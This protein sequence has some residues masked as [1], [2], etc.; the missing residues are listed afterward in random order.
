MQNNAAKYN[1]NALE[2]M[3]I[4]TSEQA[5]KVVDN[6]Q[7]RSLRKSMTKGGYDVKQQTGK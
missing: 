2:T 6:E 5:S 3:G 1:S 7:C 4:I